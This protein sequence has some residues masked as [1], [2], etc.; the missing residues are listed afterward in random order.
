MTQLTIGQDIV[1]VVSLGYDLDDQ[2]QLTISNC[3][4]IGL[5][6]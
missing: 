3:S 5:V 2:L 6:I 4:I 1:A